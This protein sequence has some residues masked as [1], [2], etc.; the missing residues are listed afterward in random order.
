[1][2]ALLTI[3]PDCCLPV[4]CI[5]HRPKRFDE[6]SSSDESSDESDSSC[7]GHDHSHASGSRRRH[8]HA[9]RPESPNNNGNADGGAN[10]RSREGGETV[11]HEVESDS[12]ERNAYER[13]PRRK[14]GKGVARNA[15]E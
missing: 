14:K 7:D 8:R 13:P 11:V 5:Y 9:H 4:C 2:I 6:S 12:D 15:N 3:H 1:M 10:L